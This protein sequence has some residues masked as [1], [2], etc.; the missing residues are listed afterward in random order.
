[1]T[2]GL[3]AHVGVDVGGTTTRAV[4][5][6]AALRPVAI[7]S[8]P[9]PHGPEP[10]AARVVELVGALRGSLDL[11]GCDPSIAV[12]M[13][14]RVDVAAGSVADAVNLGID[15]P[16][17]MGALLAGAVGCPAHLENDVNAA[18]LGTFHHL[19]LD[20]R[21]SL[22]YVNVGTGIAAG[23]VLGGRLWR[24][25]TGGAGEVGHIP[26]RAGGPP[27]P[28]GQAGCAEAIGSGRAVGYDPARRDDVFAA[29]AWTVQ[30]CVLTLDVDL[31]AIGGGLT[32]RGRPFL[33][34]LDARLA[35][36]EAAST[37][38]RSAALRRRVRLAPAGVPLGAAGAVLAA[39]A[40]APDEA[41]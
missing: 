19:G 4:A 23:F 33:E 39:R 11:S 21:S 14:G 37:L 38:L 13:P 36:R 1:M 35:E 7:E 25:S 17:A 30:L 41:R 29:V 16:V 12:C 20:A 6:D 3:V 15:A 18:A 28:C 9:T 10:I 24:G 22:A 2:D 32:E 8:G 26:M 27:C 31:V 34:A 5:F 40:A